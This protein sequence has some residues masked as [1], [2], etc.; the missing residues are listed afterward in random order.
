MRSKLYIL[1]ISL[2]G[3]VIVSIL[4]VM[5]SSQKNN[6]ANAEP[7]F[8]SS[9]AY[10]LPISEPSYFPIYDS[11]IEKPV[12]D[13]KAGIVYDTRSGRFLFTKNSRIKLPVASLTKILSAIVVLENIDTKEAVVIPKEALKVDEEK[14]SLYLGEEI[15]VQ[16]LLKLML[17]ESSNDAAY[18]L[19]WHVNGKGIGFVDK[20]NEK[21][22]SLSMNDSSFLDPAGLSDDAYST[23]EDLVKL[24]KY[25]FKHDLIWRILT[26][27]S[28][29]VKSID[30]KI[31]HNVESTDQ[32]LGVIPDIFGGKTGYTDNALGC[33]ILVVDIPDKNDK[34]ISVALGSRLRFD[35]TKK[36]I[37]WAKSAHRWD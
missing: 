15:T 17:I 12:I 25:S 31:E 9:Q 18:A 27:K 11:K 13:A 1:A 23:S 2:A 20:M 4:F 21:A 19:A 34:L 3:L 28:I 33:M 26:E 8:N 37:D 16:N 10:L 29:I 35:D 6:L 24:I 30:G 32:L 36:L 14:Q 22:R 5:D 7:A